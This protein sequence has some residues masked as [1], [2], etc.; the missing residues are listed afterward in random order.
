[1]DWTRKVNPVRGAPVRQARG[2]I[3][4]F[5]HGRIFKRRVGDDNGV[6]HLAETAADEDEQQGQAKEQGGCF[7]FHAMGLGQVSDKGFWGRGDTM[8]AE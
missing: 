6:G 4:A 5:G 8:R 1:M 7:Q 3:V 2:F